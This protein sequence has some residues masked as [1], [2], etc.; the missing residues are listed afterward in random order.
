MSRFVAHLFGCSSNPWQMELNEEN[1]ESCNVIS[2]RFVVLRNWIKG[3]QRSKLWIREFYNKIFSFHKL[4]YLSLRFFNTSKIRSIF[5]GTKS[6]LEGLL[7]KV[8]YSL[9]Q[10]HCGE[11]FFWNNTCWNRLPLKQ[12][13]IWKNKLMVMFSRISFP[14]WWISGNWERKIFSSYPSETKYNWN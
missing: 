13:K 2:C 1:V 12:R 7:T 3:R 9:A 10:F 14:F 6:I 8:L 4:E 11:I 5:L